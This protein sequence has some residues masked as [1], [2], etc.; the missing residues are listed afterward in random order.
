LVSVHVV[1]VIFIFLVYA[2]N[3]DLGSP[4]KVY[5]KLAAITTTSKQDCSNLTRLNQAC[6][7]VSGNY[8]GSFLTM[9]SSGG[10]IFGI[11]NIIG[12][13]GTVF[14]DNV[15]SKHYAS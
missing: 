10:F 13:F 7:A 6:G 8:A 3:S 1:L 12:N 5:D 9:L 4:K 11:I 14:V 15:S 2:S